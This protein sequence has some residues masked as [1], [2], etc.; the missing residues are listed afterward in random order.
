MP[1]TIFRVWRLLYF[2]WWRHCATERLFIILSWVCRPLPETS[3]KNEKLVLVCFLRAY[4]WPWRRR[5]STS[6]TG[7][8]KQ[9][10]TMKSNDDGSSKAVTEDA[11]SRPSTST[12]TPAQPLPLAKNSKGLPSSPSSTNKHL[13]PPAAKKLKLAPALPALASTSSTEKK[14][15]GGGEVS[16]LI[17]GRKISRREDLSQANNEKR[18][19]KRKVDRLQ[20]TLENIEKQVCALTEELEKTKK[21]LME[22]KE[23]NES[24]FDEKPAG[25]SVAAAS[26]DS[27]PLPRSFTFEEQFQELQHYKAGNGHCRVPAQTPRLGRWVSDIRKNYKVCQKET[28]LLDVPGLDGATDLT[29]ER[30]KRLEGKFNF[31]FS[32]PFVK[33]PLFSLK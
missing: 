32:L 22:L 27:S 29:N 15:A 14:K 9:H 33:F 16:S 23:Q 10:E 5:Q 8:A 21:E 11:S 2:V 3:I 6:S 18:N 30:I 13:V 20:T 1:D 31:F 17:P 28:S 25:V 24:K 19:L 7:S 12:K 26:T 4:A